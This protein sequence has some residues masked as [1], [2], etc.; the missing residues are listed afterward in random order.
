MW[1]NHYTSAWAFG[2]NRQFGSVYSVSLNFGFQK[3]SADR[4][5]KISKTD[6]FGFGFLVRFSV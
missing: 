1:K 2:L 3:M 4:F 5:A 6:N